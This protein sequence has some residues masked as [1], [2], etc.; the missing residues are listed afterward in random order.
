MSDDDFVRGFLKYLTAHEVGHTLGLRHNFHAS[1]IHTFE[2]L[3]DATRTGEMGLTG[4]VMDYIP[5][6][7]A[8]AGAEQGELFQTT[9][10]PYD[11]WA[12]EY[13]YKPI[14]ADSPAAELPELQ[15]I[16]GRVSEPLLAY[17]T[18]EDAGFFDEP[19]EVDPLA[20][21]FDLGAEP[22]EYYA[23][24]VQL[25]RELWQRSEDRLLK[26]GEG[27]QV[28][29]RSFGQALWN[30]GNSAYMASKYI[31]GIRYYRDHVGDPNGRTPF[32]PVPLAQQRAAL[33][34]LTTQLFA[35]D[36]FSFSPALLRKLA[37]DRYPDWVNFERMLRR[38]DVPL[39]T[40][41]L[42]MQTEVLDRVLH[43]VVLSRV[44][45]SQMYFDD[46]SQAFK[47]DA[48]FAGVQEAIWRDTLKADGLSVNTYRRALQRAHLKK[49]A[50][51]AVKD[52]GAPEDARSLARRSLTT[53]REQLRTAGKGRNVEENTRAHLEDSGARIEQVLNATV[54]RVGY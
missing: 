20:N 52:G 17:A 13:A 28:L 27:Y 10:G 16:A 34:L 38:P 11:Y 5:A 2:Q 8:A 37:G 14:A 33:N 9:I 24:R 22:L 26:T 53:L 48:L 23:H 36:A 42:G 50:D 30:I 32:D 44:L 47:L 18:D 51:L 21:R 25:G 39:H 46:P 31:G 12:V 6:N 15:K 3:Q 43:P 41:L 29:R 54:Q 7:L 49:L 35:P 19:F 40:M 1:T 45:D 4:S